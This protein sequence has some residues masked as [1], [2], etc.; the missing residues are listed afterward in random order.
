MD[1]LRCTPPVGSVQVQVIV[2]VGLLPPVS[3]ATSLIVVPTGAEAG[4][5]L[6]VGRA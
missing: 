2:P 6:V 3:V 4:V 1:G 5:A